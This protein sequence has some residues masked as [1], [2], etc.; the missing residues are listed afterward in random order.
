MGNIIASPLHKGTHRDGDDNTRPAKR[1]RISSPEAV[2]VNHLVAS[3]VKSDSCPGLRIEVLKFLHKDSKKVKGGYAATAAPVSH[4]FR[5]SKTRCKITISDTSSEIPQVLY[6]QS[7]ICD[8]TTVDNPVGPFQISLVGLPQPFFIAKDSLCINRADDGTFGLSDAYQLL[9][10]LEAANGA[11]WPPIS[12]REDDLPDMAQGARQDRPEHWVL[13]STFD[14]ISGRLKSR[15]DLSARHLGGHIVHTD[16]V[17]EVDVKWSAG[18]K[19][20]KSVEKDSKP[21]IKA[22]D[23]DFDIFTDVSTTSHFSNGLTNGIN[24]HHQDEDHED[25]ATGALTPSRSLRA[26]EKN[27][28]YNL[29]VLSDQALG[30]SGK[31]RGRIANMPANSGR[32][33][34]LLPLDQP[35]SLDYNRCVACGTYHESLDQLQLHLKTSHPEFVH[36]LEYTNQGPLLRISAVQ[37]TVKTPQKTHNLIRA[38]EPFNLQTLLAGDSSWLTA[39]LGPDYHDDI[40]NSPSARRSVDRTQSW[41]PVPRTP[42]TSRRTTRAK[43]NKVLL[44]DNLHDCFDPISKAALQAGQPIPANVPDDTWLIQ[45]HRESIS[46][47]SDVTAEEKEYIWE[48][49]GYILNQNL[50]SA[51]Y[52]ARAWLKFVR[53]K[54]DWLASAD[55]RMIEFGKHTSYL[56]SRDLLDDED[57]EQAFSYINDARS[58]LVTNQEE[59][60]EPHDGENG[61][62]VTRHSPKSADICKSADGCTICQLPVIGPR[63]LLCSNTV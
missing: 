4:D 27:K 42:T 61:L 21:C 62:T 34:Y 51:P 11:P 57:M 28:V 37:E 5:T 9:I 36:V 3:P 35:V 15:L 19:P 52:F 25:D 41:S 16:Y 26:R 47:F 54:A 18:F 49:D 55:R 58:N 63:I 32:V 22:I 17:V 13:T 2:G 6:C 50:S 29:K 33:L 8:L 53:E 46:D 38:V 59:G 45:R 60:I 1:R 56:L 40:V 12:P 44:P 20:S 30:R 39:R 23:P 31:R 43:P 10:E 7:Q 48:W 24:G 14:N